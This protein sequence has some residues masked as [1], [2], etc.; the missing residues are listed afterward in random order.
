MYLL[1]LYLYLQK[2]TNS[3]TTQVVK[4]YSPKKNCGKSL[5]NR[6]P[7]ESLAMPFSLPMT[8]N[9]YSLN[10]LI[11][12]LDLNFSNYYFF[13]FINKT[14]VKLLKWVQKKLCKST[15]NNDIRNYSHYSS[16]L[17]WVVNI[18]KILFYRKRWVGRFAIR[19]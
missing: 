15:E 6:A 5:K 11:I 17:F 13:P 14:L 8:N 16:F 19:S 7:V 10:N 2:M 9:N 18:F 3:F 4:K 1:P 12:V